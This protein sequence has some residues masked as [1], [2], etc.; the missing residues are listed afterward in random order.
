MIV[1]DMPVGPCCCDRMRRYIGLDDVG[2]LYVAKFR[3]YGLPVLDGGPSF[4]VIDFC[5]WCGRRL[6]AS[7]RDKWF[8][9]IERLGLEPDSPSL[10]ARYA[11]DEWWRCAEGH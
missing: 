9:E 7:L 6:P 5:P 2:I 10:P 4:I 11:T 8:E 1:S 3:E